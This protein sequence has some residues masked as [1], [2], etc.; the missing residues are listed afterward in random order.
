MV[1]AAGRGER[2]R[3]LTDHTPKPLIPVHGRPMIEW[4]LE[5]LAACGVDEVVINTSWLGDRFPQALGDGSRWGLALRYI[6]EGAVPLETGGGLLN[7]LPR[8]GREPFWLVN[9]DVFTDYDFSRLTRRPAGLAHLVMV[10]TA[11]HTPGGD[12]ALGEDGLLHA[13]GAAKLTYAGIGCYDPA[14]LDDWQ[15]VIGELAPAD[16]DPPRFRLAPLLRA[17]MQRGQVSGELHAG[18][19]TDVGTP[20]RLRQLEAL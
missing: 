16:R 7:A 6:D 2:L 8:L 5:R 17:A 1:F 10:P 4:H 9:G 14:L 20:E 15:Q 3:P 18:H 13:E 12:F 19:W 11:V